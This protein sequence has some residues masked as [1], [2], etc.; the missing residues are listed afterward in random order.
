MDAAVIA[1]LA[2]GVGLEALCCV[3]VWVA[4]DVFDKLH[5]TGPAAVVAPTPI[6]LAI[7]ME[8]RISQAP[9]KAALVVVLLAALGPL[10]SH[11]TAR[12]ARIRQFGNWEPRDEER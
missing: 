5:F 8:E 1:L 7:V 4:G 9:L 2:I 10:L 3:G 12:S 6:A 11:A